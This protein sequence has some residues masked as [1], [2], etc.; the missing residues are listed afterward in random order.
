MLECPF[1]LY[2]FTTQNR[3]VKYKIT[4]NKILTKKPKMHLK[5]IINDKKRAPYKLFN[6]LIGVS[7]IYSTDIAL[8]LFLLE[9]N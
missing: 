5:L 2:Q 3:L 8:H 7:Y 6:S 4:D 1:F 9:K